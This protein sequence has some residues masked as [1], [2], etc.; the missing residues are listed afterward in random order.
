MIAEASLEDLREL[1]RFLLD[2]IKGRRA[3]EDR[4]ALTSLRPGQ[5]VR[6]AGDRHSQGL[7]PHQS[8]GVVKELRKTRV[9]VTFERLF[10]GPIDLICPPGILE[11]IAV[12]GPVPEED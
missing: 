4:R 5:R 2:E 12:T 7:I 10:G 6:Y 3:V 8:E 11:N 1:N 9:L